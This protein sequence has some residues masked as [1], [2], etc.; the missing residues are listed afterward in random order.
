[1]K[2]KD[3]A[4]I[5]RY[6]SGS[7]A[8][9]GED[10]S[11]I[12]ILTIGY[13]FFDMTRR[14]AKN[15]A[16]AYDLMN[17]MENFKCNVMDIT[18]SKVPEYVVRILVA[19]G[20]CLIDRLN[21]QWKKGK[22][23]EAGI[24]SDLANPGNVCR[25]LK[26]DAQPPEVKKEIIEWREVNYKEKLKYYQKDYY[27]IFC[28][29]FLEPTLKDMTD[30]CLFP[31]I[32]G[33]NGTCY[34][35][36]G[37][38]GVEFDVLA[39]R[40]GMMNSYRNAFPYHRKPF[41]S[42]DPCYDYVRATRPILLPKLSL[43]RKKEKGKM[44]EFDVIEPLG[45]VTLEEVGGEFYKPKVKAAMKVVT[46]EDIRNAFYALIKAKT[47]NIMAQNL[48][49]YI[50][51]N[52]LSTIWANLVNH[53]HRTRGEDF[54][55]LKFLME[56]DRF[57]GIVTQATIIRQKEEDIEPEEEPDPPV[58]SHETSDDDEEEVRSG[59]EGQEQDD[60][61]DDLNFDDQMTL[62]DE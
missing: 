28:L 39:S 41:I 13:Y 17:L 20:K 42:V 45:P 16:L 23:V 31:A 52:R 10:A 1:M 30:V 25:Y 55:L 8:F 50:D 3:I 37:P 49:D 26:I 34:I 32:M 19:N 44:F 6:L 21:S 24:F 61:K 29:G 57:V 62:E 7:R 5:W 9:R 14:M 56:D 53:V 36:L 40:C 15:I 51:E 54:Q 48:I 22:D 60:K 33:H 18:G 46:D 47:V 58:K 38:G 2:L 4:K 11:G 12:G 27:A 35:G 59:H 43:G